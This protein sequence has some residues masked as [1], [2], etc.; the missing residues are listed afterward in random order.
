KV[1][2]FSWI[3]LNPVALHFACSYTKKPFVEKR[4]FLVLIYLPFLL[5]HGMYVSDQYKRLVADKLFGWV[6]APD[7]S[8]IDAL[9]M[10]VMTGT[11]F[12]I[13]G[14]LLA[15][16]Y[17][18]RH[19]ARRRTQ[20]ILVAMGILVPTVVGFISQVLFPLVF[21]IN[22]LPLAPT[23][24]TMFS[25]FTIV[26]LVRYRLFDISESVSLGMVLRQFQNIVL[27]VLPDRSVQVLNQYSSDL[28]G[29]SGNRPLLT[30]HCF[31]SPEAAEEF[32]IQVLQPAFEGRALRNNMVFFEAGQRAVNTLVSVE[33]VLYRNKVQAVLVVANDITEYLAVVEQRKH[34]E[35]QLEAEQLRRHREI[36]EAVIAAQENER[37]I[38]GAELHDNVNQILTSAKLYLG[39]AATAAPADSGRFLE[40]TGGIIV[41]AMQEV[42]KL[43]HSLIPPT[44]S[45]ETLVEAMRHL[46]QGPAQAGFEV[47]LDVSRFEEECVPSKLKLTVYRIVQEQW[48]NIIKHAGAQ[49]VTVSLRNYCN[50]L[51]LLIT[52]DGIGFDPQQQAQGVGLKN[53]STRALLHGGRVSVQS[54]PDRGCTLRVEFPLSVA[55]FSR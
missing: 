43:S 45:G 40:Q 9:L 8:F 15:F 5:L 39:L 10:W 52:D 51:V 19:D 28:F 53:I 48:S 54:A 14:M 41:Q 35:R 12:L 44:L 16:A 38:I 42:R 47:D 36:T 30:T 13:T 26:A 32:D 49:Q 29:A 11:M 46:L 3:L 6:I 18:V 27:A 22:E 20:A 1:F 33:P 17:Q 23:L 31:G 7:T 25:L 37:R 34:A 50:E 21:G 2:C 24:V 55:A 4:L